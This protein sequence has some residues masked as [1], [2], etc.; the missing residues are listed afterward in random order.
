MRDPRRALG[1]AGERVTALYLEQR[2]YRILGRNVRLKGGEID[3]VADH[4]GCLVIVEV[5][6]RRGAGTG[7]AL[8]SVARKKQERLRR[9][10]MEYCA[11]RRRPNLY[12]LTWSAYHSTVVD[13]SWTWC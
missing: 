8:E 2:G 11:G 12:G 9:L 13:V 7:I 4:N 10:S 6:L 5:R 3:I 1:A